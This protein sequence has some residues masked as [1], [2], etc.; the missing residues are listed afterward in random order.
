VIGAGPIGV[1]VALGLRAGGWERV[2]VIERNEQRRARI[3]RFG[4]TAVG[5]DGVHMAVL[6]ALGGELPAAVF[7]CAGH[8]SAAQLAIELIAIS[9]RVVLLG[10]LEEPVPISQLVMMVKEA[11]LAASFAYLPENFRASIELL[12]AG[13]IPADELITAM[14]DLAEAS[15]MFKELVR[16][17][18]EHLKVLLRP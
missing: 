13:R 15:K 2:V 14:V 3:E 18:T 5:L 12:A 10:V 9:G 16:P 7:E 17:E 4:F 1:M 8:P 6:D 11:E